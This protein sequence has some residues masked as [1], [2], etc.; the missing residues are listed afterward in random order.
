MARSERLATSLGAALLVLTMVSSCGQVTGLTD[1]YVYD[2]DEPDAA[3]EG[4]GDGAGDGG[5][6]CSS[7]D[8]ARALSSIGSAGGQ[9]V[10]TQCKTCLSESCCSEISACAADDSCD[11][12]MK[13]IFGCQR[14][15]NRQQC[16]SS[17]GPAFVNT[18]GACLQ[19]ACTS[20]TCQLR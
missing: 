8:R 9:D 12:S 2:L 14:T 10:S 1:D 20:P 4:G 16:L 15:G 13:C 18:V 3:S 6:Q 19:T 11:E 5:G 7:G 17:C